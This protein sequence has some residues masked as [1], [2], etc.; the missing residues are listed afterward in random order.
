[1]NKIFLKSLLCCYSLLLMTSCVITRYDARRAMVQSTNVSYIATTEVSVGDWM[2][3]MMATSFTEGK[4]PIKLGDHYDKISSKLPA[5]EPGRW[6]H[7]TIS[8]FLRKSEKNVVVYLYNDCRDP[9]QTVSVSEAAW[10]SIQKYKLMYLPIAGITYEQAMDYMAYKQEAV[11]SCDFKAK[12]TFRYECF[13]PTPE[14]FQIVQTKLD[15]TNSLG[16]N[17]FNYVNSLCADCP[18]GEKYLKNPVSSRTGKE[19]TSVLGYYPDPF[20][21]YN[22]KG[23]VAEMTSVKGIAMGG[24]CEHYATEAFDGA[25]QMYAGSAGWLGFRVWYRKIP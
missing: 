23:N 14:Q 6:D 18:N 7:Y 15:S 11:N 12:D 16:C 19:P 20:G 13:L 24:S 3:Y 9:V 1:M 5:L 2:V 25:K 8:A 17:L 22:F 10:D 21:L 4:Q